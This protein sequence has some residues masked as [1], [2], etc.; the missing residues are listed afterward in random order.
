MTLARYDMK[1]PARLIHEISERVPL[2]RD[3]A[4]VVLVRDPSTT[5]SIVTIRRLDEPALRDDDE[6][7][8][9][10]DELREVA[11]SMDVPDAHPTRHSLVTVLVRPGRTIL[12]P[13]ERVWF[14]GWRYSNHFQR[15]FDG[16]L[17]VVTEHGWLDS[18]TNWAGHEPRMLA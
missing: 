3:T 16:G 10:R 14:K 13:N 12:G 9:M 18:H 6:W 17:I 11:Q 5:Q 4:Y 2:T 15:A 8:E 1:D 7:L